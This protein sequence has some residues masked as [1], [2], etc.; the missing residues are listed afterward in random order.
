M[1]VSSHQCYLPLLELCWTRLP[2]FHNWGYR[3]SL[4]AG[5]LASALSFLFFKFLNIYLFL[6]E[7]ERESTSGRGAEREGDTASEA[8][9]RLRAVSTEPDVGLEPTNHEIMT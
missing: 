3:S 6:R 2:S 8:G 5:F 1:Y 4:L 9:S 7:K